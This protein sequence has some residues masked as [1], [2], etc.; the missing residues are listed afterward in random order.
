MRWTG[1]LTLE[2]ARTAAAG[3]W[4]HAKAELGRR[5]DPTIVTRLMRPVHERSVRHLKVLAAEW[6]VACAD[7]CSWCCRGIKVGILPVEAVA[8]VQHLTDNLSPDKLADVRRRV[9]AVAEQARTMSGR[10]FR[11]AQIACPLLDEAE[12]RCSVY[13]LRPLSCRGYVSVDARACE[14]A[15]KTSGTEAMAPIVPDYKLVIEAASQA[16]QVAFDDLRIEARLFEL[17]SALLVALTVA[18]AGT[19]WARGKRVFNSALP[20]AEETQH[21]EMLREMRQGLTGTRW[22]ED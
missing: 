17:S 15:L 22:Q 13:G 19:Q 2:L 4:T 18:D 1:A 8:I 6:D 14:A 7:R 16:L 12:G 10:D 5:R 3:E 20:T 21:Q 9:E 11:I